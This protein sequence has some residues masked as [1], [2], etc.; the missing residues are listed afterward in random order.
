MIA[1]LLFPLALLFGT[2][3]IELA[4]QTSSINWMTFEE[5]IEANK[6]EPRKILIDVYTV[7]CGPCRMMNSETFGNDSVIQYVNKHY[8]AVKFNAEG[9]D[10][11]R[12]GEQIF[13]N[14]NYD[15]AKARGRN[16]THEFAM[17][18]AVINGRLSYPTVVYFDEDI[19][20]LSPVPGFIR[21]LE[22][23]PILRFF[24]ENHY[25]KGT[26]EDYQKAFTGTFK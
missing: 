4:A 18:I 2:L 20:I 24:A 16:G 15:P 26:W 12:F 1:R 21:P 22:I 7:W 10:T 11:V 23:E 19:K 9:N 5:A 17:A 8:Y 13:V 25:L 6:K 3:Q 14:T